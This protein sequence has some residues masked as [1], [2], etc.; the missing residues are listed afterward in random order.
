MDNNLEMLIEFLVELVSVAAV[1]VGIALG[2]QKHYIYFL[3]TVLGFV[4]IFIYQRI[5]RR[6]KDK[7]IKEILKEQW[8][9]E[10]NTKRDFSKIR[11]LYDFLIRRENFHFTIDDITWSDLDM[12][13]VFS[14]LDHTMS[15]PG[16]QY[17]YHMLRLPVY[18]EDFLKKRNKTINMLMENKALSNRLQF[19]LFI[20]GKEKGEDIIKF[21][22]KGINIDTRPLIIYRLL[23]FLPLVGIALLFYDIG[24]GFIAIMFIVSTN[25]FF[26]NKNKRAINLEIENFKYIGDLILCAESIVKSGIGEIELVH[27]EME[28]VLKELKA[29][30]K[31]IL[32]LRYNDSYRSEM[33]IIIDYLNMLVLRE[34]KIFYKTVSLLNIHREDLLSLYIMIGQIDAYISVASYKS[35]L[36]YYIEPSL[37]ENHG[38]YL[39]AE[40]IY[41]PLLE[42]PVPYTVEL[43]NR[44]ALITGSN[45]SGKSTFLKTMG[46]N[47]LFA[48]TLYFTFSEKYSSCYFRLFSS[49]GTTD[50]IV[51][52]DSYFMAEAKALKRVIDSIDGGSPILCILDEIFRGT[53]TAER[54][55]AAQVVLDYLI[56]K[57]NCVIAAT[58]DLELTSLVSEKY[59]NYHFRETIDDND[60]SFDYI[61]RTGPCVSSNAIAILKYIGYPKEIYEAAKEKA[62]KYLIKA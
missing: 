56:E 32:K 47:S 21:F 24:I 9:K 38:F 55:S 43:N 60:I 46:I 15:L 27:K 53:N 59:E 48:Q 3:V 5:K 6:I 28:E 49:I 29:L 34:P 33:E 19:P 54:I 14:K 2:I 42:E 18:K 37:K 57:G 51:E 7:K 52:G 22:D 26:Y 58:H 39:Y 30:K 13:L 8:G 20:L 1:I 45:A 40:K 62:E 50:S 25:L 11:E 10:R 36:R 4:T 41:H 61:L 17:L 23:S 44:G 12:D 16:M 35:S 31:N